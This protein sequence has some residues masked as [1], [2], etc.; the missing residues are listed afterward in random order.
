M[1]LVILLII[2]VYEISNQSL[3]ATQGLIF[4]FVIKNFG[5]YVS[6]IISSITNLVKY[7]SGLKG[8]EVVL[9]DL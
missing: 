7:Y 6:S 2:I 4:I 1:L 9:Q 5:A 3:T 8:V